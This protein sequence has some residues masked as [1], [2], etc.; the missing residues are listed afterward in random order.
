MKNVPHRRFGTLHNVLD[1]D[2]HGESM[3]RPILPVSREILILDG[4][5][6]RRLISQVIVQS[7]KLVNI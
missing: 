7:Y 1:A 6:G 5:G 3:L 2:S 4:L